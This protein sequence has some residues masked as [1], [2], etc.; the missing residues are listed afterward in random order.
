M[1]FESDYLTN[2]VTGTMSSVPAPNNNHMR[3]YTLYGM[4]TVC[5]P[6]AILHKWETTYMCDNVNDCTPNNLDI[7]SLISDIDSERL[8]QQAHYDRSSTSSIL[9]ELLEEQQILIANRS[10]RVKSLLKQID[11]LITAAKE[12]TSLFGDI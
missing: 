9:N 10:L 5:N 4:W 8:D 12:G 11:S 6:F 3:I 2:N 7:L 1:I